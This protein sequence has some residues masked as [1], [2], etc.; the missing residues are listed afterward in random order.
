MVDVDALMTEVVRAQ[1]DDKELSKI[2]TLLR[3]GGG[4]AHHLPRNY[5]MNADVLRWDGVMV[6]LAQGYAKIKLDILRSRHDSVA[7][8]HCGR[9]KT[10]RLVRWDYYWRGMTDY[11][12]RYVNKCHKCARNKT[13]R[14]LKYGKLLPLPIPERPFASLSMD[15]IVKLPKSGAQGYNCILVVVYCFTK[16]AHF[17]PTMETNTS[18]DLAK[19]FIQRIYCAHGLP[20]NVVSN[21]GATFTSTFWKS[22]SASSLSSPPRT[23]RRPMDRP[24]AST[25]SLR[26]TCASS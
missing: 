19:T 26:S 17:I 18:E 2:R 9:D 22:L 15:H 10:Y 20:D 12:N 23:I 11:V 1:K 6:I 16:M 8:G 3:N 5:S 7:A 13:K 25:R 21:C 4:D 24:S 14:H